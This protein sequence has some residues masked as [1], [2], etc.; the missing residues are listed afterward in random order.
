MP[1]DVLGTEEEITRMVYFL[2]DKVCDDEVFCSIFS[3]HV[4]D[5]NSHLPVISDFW[6]SAHCRTARFGSAPVPKHTALPGLGIELFQRSLMLFG[7]TTDALPHTAF[8]QRARDLARRIAQSLWYGYLMSQR[9]NRLAG[10]AA[11]A[12]SSK[13]PNQ[14]QR[15]R[16]RHH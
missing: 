1:D 11:G 8:G 10:S 3:Q 7:E 15:A 12:K 6:S 13:R 16:L 14:S 4:S 2:Y 5:W 9:P